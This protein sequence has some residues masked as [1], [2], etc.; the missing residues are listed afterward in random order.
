MS[1]VLIGGT[2]ITNGGQ[3]TRLQ[4]TWFWVSALYLSIILVYS[5]FTGVTLNAFTIAGESKFSVYQMVAK[6]S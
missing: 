5:Y 4:K 6:I 1:P 3:N 2:L